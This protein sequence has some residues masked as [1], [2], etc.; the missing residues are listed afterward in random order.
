MKKIEITKAEEVIRQ[1]LKIKE[2]PDLYC[3]L[4]EVT[5]EIEHFHKA[6]ELSKNR[7]ARAFRMLAKFYFSKEK[8]INLQ[9]TIIH[10]FFNFILFKK[11][12]MKQ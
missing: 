11:S 7:S 5:K 6:I 4:G 3:S 9:Y 8:V 2:T 12:M 1:Q 10:I